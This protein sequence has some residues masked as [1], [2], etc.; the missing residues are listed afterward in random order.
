MTSGRLMGRKLPLSPDDLAALARESLLLGPTGGDRCERRVPGARV[1][2]TPGIELGP[3]VPAVISIG[4]FD[5]LHLGHRALI[6]DALE[7]ARE[8]GVP[9]VVV[10]FDPDP[11]DYLEGV[12]PGTRL[13]EVDDRVRAI[14]ALGVDAV[15]TFDFDARLAGTGHESY[16]RDVLP[17]VVRPVRVH[18]GANFR[19]GAGGLGTVDVLREDGR[20]LG[21]DVRGHA[22]TL[23]GGEPISSTRIRGLLGD[24]DVEGA[25]RLLGRP[26]FV[27]GTVT[28]GRGEGTSFGFPTANVRVP[29]TTC[30]PAAGVYACALRSGGS[31]WP[32]AA[33]VGEPPTFSPDGEE[34]PEGFLEA[35]LMGYE[36]DLYGDEVEVVFL[37]WLRA[38][39]AFASTDELE[40]VVMENIGWVR[41][42]IGRAGTGVLS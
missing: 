25:A 18:V 7:D 22:L 29:L 35:N 16:L 34:G 13:L 5:G 24:G 20:S 31:V 36:G 37:R 40:R 28:H 39:R 10:T 26:H 12:R 1:S 2:A 14:C 23:D 41:T 42:N 27:R 4:A 21:I 30:M 32:A 33:N 6:A 15:V 38:S 8:M 19:L 9:C 11:A 17:A 3:E